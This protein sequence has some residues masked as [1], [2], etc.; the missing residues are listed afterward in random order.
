MVYK[1][2]VIANEAGLHARPAVLF[3]QEAQK[4][5]SKITV[6]KG[7]KQADAKSIL[8]VM[9]LAVTKGTSILIVAEGEDEKEAV[10]CLVNLIN[11]K[12][13]EGSNDV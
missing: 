3:V 2:V 1:Q 11:N 12:F 6:H 13:G 10:E 9:S 5:K 8:G 7:D 4:F